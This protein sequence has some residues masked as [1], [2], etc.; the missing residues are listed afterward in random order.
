MGLGLCN[1]THCYQYNPCEHDCWKNNILSVTARSTDRPH[2]TR[3]RDLNCEA[4]KN[5]H[6]FFVMTCQICLYLNNYWYTYTLI[7]LE[8]NHMKIVHL[9]WRV[10]LYCLVKCSILQVL[11][12]TSEHRSCHVSLNVIIIFLNIQ[13][14]HYT[15]DAWL[16]VR[17][18]NVIC[19][20]LKCQHEG[21]AMNIM[22]HNCPTAIIGEW[23]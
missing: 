23:K 3:S 2:R 18:S 6:H 14:K 21:E 4:K 11:W 19:P 9:F 1:V 5:L 8:Q 13:M 17:Q 7:N 12:P 22:H 15:N 10:S 16:S 20:K